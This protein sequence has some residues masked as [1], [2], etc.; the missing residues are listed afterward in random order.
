MTPP[1]AAPPPA[2]GD[3]FVVLTLL[4]RQSAAFAAGVA[5]GL[6]ADRA[7]LDVVHIVASVV[8]GLVFGG[9]LGWVYGY[10]A[11]PAKSA[12]VA[13]VRMG[14]SALPKAFL[15]AV[16][17]ALFGAGGTAWVAGH[18]VPAAVSVGFLIGSAMA[19]GILV[20]IFFVITASLA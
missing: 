2:P 14:R 5:G 10:V 4:C 1:V 15:A 17:P 11:F 9:L 12:P 20:G 3:K 7:G 6:I 18:F 19:A 8:G 13:V 16:L